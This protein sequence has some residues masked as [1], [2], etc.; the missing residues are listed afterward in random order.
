MSTP[1]TPIKFRC[2]QCGKTLKVSSSRAGQTVSCP[3]CSAE[4]IVP[5]APA[6]APAAEV[7]HAPAAPESPLAFL[8]LN[9]ESAPA[10]PAAEPA[11]FFPSIQT[12]PSA[13]AAE[14]AFSIRT[15]PPPKVAA[16]PTK[17]A[18]PKPAP[19][20]PK[21]VAPMPPLP[22]S[23]ANEPFFPSIQTES[24]SAAT[25]AEPV[26]SPF[27][28]IQAEPDPIRHEAAAHRTTPA[29][30]SSSSSAPIAVADRGLRRNDVVLPRT[31]VVLWTFMV[32]VAVVSAFAAGLLLG[33]FVWVKPLPPA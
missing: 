17:T 29:P 13:P 5:E 33:H 26:A 28:M 25:H 9:T 4:L 15:E 16:M 8:N 24:P 12:E 14:P 3:S 20:A 23:H 22:P 30:A 11:A 27:P 6:E 7:A 1:G 18:S 21:P 31:A 32:L 10:H 19:P 2:F